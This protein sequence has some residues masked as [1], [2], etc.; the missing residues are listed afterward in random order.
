MPPNVTELRAH[1]AP[2]ITIDADGSH[3]FRTWQMIRD[4]GIWWPWFAP[5]RA[6]LRRVEADF[7]AVSLHTAHLRD[8]APARDARAGIVHAA[9]DQDAAGSAKTIFGS[10]SLYCEF[11]PAA[12][13]WRS[14][15]VHVSALDTSIM[16]RCEGDWVLT[17]TAPE[18]T[19]PALP[20]MTCIGWGLGTLGPVTVL[21]AT[22]VVL[23]RYLTDYVGIAAGVG[24]SLIA[25]SKVFDAF[26]DP[27]LGAVSD[28]TKSPLGATT[29][30]SDYRQRFAFYCSCRD[31]F[32]PRFCGEVQDAR[33]SMS[34]RS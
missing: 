14:I 7:D 30:L 26:I 18:P 25:F 11:G 4:M 6:N 21:T 3:W 28:R 29:A 32:G 22:N 12:C 10:G 15:I 13:D 19:A 17:T 1:F 16:D 9:L 23:L 20:L 33:Q 24:A 5:T 8:D 27:G 31:L 2:P 34:G